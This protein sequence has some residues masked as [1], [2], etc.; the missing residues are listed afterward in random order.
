MVV[1]GNPRFRRLLE[2]EIPAF[3]VE[4]LLECASGLAESTVDQGLKGRESPVRLKRPVQFFLDVHP[5]S[6]DIANY[7]QK[8]VPNRHARRRET[9]L[10]HL[11]GT[12]VPVAEGFRVHPKTCQP[13]NDDPTLLRD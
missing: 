9:I 12:Q 1:R 8:C 2:S 11:I 10:D 7:F 3:E 13:Q 4:R 5:N 6:F